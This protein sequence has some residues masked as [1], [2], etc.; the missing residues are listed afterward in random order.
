MA[1]FCGLLN[2]RV[3]Y[4]RFAFAKKPVTSLRRFYAIMFT[5]FL[6]I[7]SIAEYNSPLP[8]VCIDRKKVGDITHDMIRSHLP[9]TKKSVTSLRRVYGMMFAFFV[10]LVN[11]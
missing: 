2:A 6:L 10:D 7:W 9:I 5:F 1:R 3:R 8:R 4:L 11:R